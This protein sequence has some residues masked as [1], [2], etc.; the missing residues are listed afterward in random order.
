MPYRPSP[1]NIDWLWAYRRSL[2]FTVK[3]NHTFSVYYQEYPSSLHM[4]LYHIR[5]EDGRKKAL[6]YDDR[7]GP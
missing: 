6:I 5:I 2:H 4:S 7:R 3:N 1:A